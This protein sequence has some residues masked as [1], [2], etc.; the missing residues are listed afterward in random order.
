MPGRALIST[1]LLTA[2]LAALLAGCGAAGDQWDLPMS[3]QLRPSDILLQDK[4][5]C[6]ALGAERI[7]VGCR[8]ADDAGSTEIIVIPRTDTELDQYSGAVDGDSV[9]WIG[10]DRF[11]AIQLSNGSSSDGLASCRIAVDVAPNEVLLVVYRQQAADPRLPPC[12]PARDFT[13]KALEDL[14]TRKS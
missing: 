13:T 12:R 8:V 5:I 9:R 14:Q 6:A 4:D 10:V 1:A 2:G 11:P 3:P 7:S